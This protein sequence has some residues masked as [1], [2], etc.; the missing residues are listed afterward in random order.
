MWVAHHRVKIQGHSF[1]FMINPSRKCRACRTSVQLQWYMT[2]IGSLFYNDLASMA[3]VCQRCRSLPCNCDPKENLSVS[4]NCA[5]SL[6]QNTFGYKGHWMKCVFCFPARNFMWF[7]ELF[8]DVLE[9][10][11]CNS[12]KLA[13]LSVTVNAD[14]TTGC[15]WA[16]FG[17]LVASAK[18]RRTK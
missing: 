10:H 1:F 16:P 5:N 11:R 7:V 6:V 8:T 9:V 14:I 12:R 13:V 17:R 18:N 3:C 4:T 15:D 2:K